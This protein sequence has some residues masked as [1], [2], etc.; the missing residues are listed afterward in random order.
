M[1]I[2][3]LQGVMFCFENSKLWKQKLGALEIKLKKWCLNPTFQTFWQHISSRKTDKQTSKMFAMKRKTYQYQICQLPSNKSQRWV[4]PI[5][6]SQPK[7]K[8]QHLSYCWG[9]KAC[10]NTQHERFKNEWF[11]L[12]AL[13]RLRGTR[14]TMWLVVLRTCQGHLTPMTSTRGKVVTHGWLFVGKISRCTCH[15]QRVALPLYGPE[16]PGDVDLG[17]RCSWKGIYIRIRKVIEIQLR[18]T[19]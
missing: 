15:T 2:P 16:N 19:I 1:E 18:T 14:W 6:F 3:H 11:K 9:T 12:A 10:Q 8:A 17:K 5:F 7:K 13:G 4:T